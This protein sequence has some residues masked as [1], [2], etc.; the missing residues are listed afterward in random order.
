MKKVTLLSTVALF[1]F[2][3]TSFAQVS[4]PNNLSLN[5]NQFV[6]FNGG[7]GFGP[8]PLQIRNDFNQPITMHTNGI[9]RA[10]INETSVNNI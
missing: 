3:T 9:Q 8:Q 2:G 5:A 7:G 4:T 10:S 1:L 6:G